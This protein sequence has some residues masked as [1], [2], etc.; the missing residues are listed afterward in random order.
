MQAGCCKGQ[1]M[2]KLVIKQETTDADEKRISDAQQQIRRGGFADAIVYRNRVE[3][4]LACATL[5]YI[6]LTDAFSIVADPSHRFCVI[7][8]KNEKDRDAVSDTVEVLKT[9]LY[10]AKHRLSGGRKAS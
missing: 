3:T 4:E 2:V 1:G 5:A 6:R 9:N 7:G 8:M 10:K